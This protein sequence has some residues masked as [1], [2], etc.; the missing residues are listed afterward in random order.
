MK[1]RRINAWA[2]VTK[3]GKWTDDAFG[4]ARIFHGRPKFDV[5]A[6]ERIIRVTVTIT[7]AKHVAK[8]G[9]K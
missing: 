9:R 2:I 5:G 6:N 1:T 8:R 4:S 7:A 3:D